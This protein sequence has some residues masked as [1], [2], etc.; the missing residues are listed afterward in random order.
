MK[1]KINIITRT[2]N[3]PNFFRRNRKSITSQSYK[4]INHLV[5]VDEEKSKKYVEQNGIF[6]Y[7]YFDQKLKQKLIK[8][9][10]KNKLGSKF[11]P[12]N[13]YFNEI[14]KNVNNGWIILLDDDDIFVDTKSVEKIIKKINETNEDTLIM[15]QMNYIGEKI[16][17]IF[18][19][20][21]VNGQIGGSCFAFH[22]KWKDFFIWDCWTCADYRAFEKLYEKI[23]N[24]SWINETLVKVDNLGRGQKKDI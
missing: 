15:W 19:L 7:V 6:N 10:K 13:L 12:H 5:G 24:K 18:D 16:P 17:K 8:K 21:P 11:L 4:N 22:N 1:T 9:Y 3:R 20:K 23:P 14:L 2:S